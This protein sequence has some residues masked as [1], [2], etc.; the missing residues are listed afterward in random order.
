M[1]PHNF[2]NMQ[3]KLADEKIKLPMVGGIT[4]SHHVTRLTLS[5]QQATSREGLVLF[6]ATSKK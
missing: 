4:L 2:V 6:Q 1:I 5:I 3:V